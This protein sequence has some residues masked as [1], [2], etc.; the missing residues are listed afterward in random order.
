MSRLPW[1]EIHA[2]VAKRAHCFSL[3]ED[4]ALDLLVKV[5]DGY[6]EHMGKT[7]D[8]QT[9]EDVKGQLRREALDLIGYGTLVE[10]DVFY[11]DDVLLE[12]GRMGKRLLDLLDGGAR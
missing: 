7:G 11:R 8:V 9:V 4:Q 5:R 3:T 10:D 2:N 1:S 6:E 12:C